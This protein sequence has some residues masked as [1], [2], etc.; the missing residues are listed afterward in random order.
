MKRLKSWLTPAIPGPRC[1]QIWMLQLQNCWW[2]MGWPLGHI[3]NMKSLIKQSQCQKF[4][5]DDIGKL[6]KKIQNFGPFPKKVYKGSTQTCNLSNFVATVEL[7]LCDYGEA[8]LAYVYNVVIFSLCLANYPQYYYHSYN[9]PGVSSVSEISR[10]EQQKY[11]MKIIWQTGTN[12]MMT[13]GQSVSWE[14]VLKSI[15][16]ISSKYQSTQQMMVEIMVNLCLAVMRSR[17]VLW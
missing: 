2:W 11:F 6:L 14:K 7:Y 13:P 12:V 15:L 1:D 8:W 5:F 4:N 16:G 17:V 3:W 10:P 9:V